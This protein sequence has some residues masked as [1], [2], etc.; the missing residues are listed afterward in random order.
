MGDLARP[1]RDRCR[2]G[3]R[4]RRVAPG[5]GRRA[6][7]RAVGGCRGR[8]R[9]GG[10]RA[11]RRTRAGGAGAGAAAA[12]AGAGLVAHVLP[13]ARRGVP[14]RAR[15]R[16]RVPHL[17]RPRDG[18]RGVRRGVRER[19][20]APGGGGARAVRSGPRV[21]SG[22]RVRRAFAERRGGPRRTPRPF[23]VEGPLAGRERSRALGGARGDASSRSGRSMVRR[24]SGRSRPPG[25]R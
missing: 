2:R 14:V 7:R 17:P 12:A 18:R 9:R 11:V 6:A 4:D 23:R 24:R 13:A 22:P 5:G 20:A 10:G 21:G 8:A 16:A 15:P 1:A 25:W 3:R 19:P